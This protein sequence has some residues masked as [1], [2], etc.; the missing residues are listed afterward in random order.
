MNKMR[1][2]WSKNVVFPERKNNF[3]PISLNYTMHAHTG[4]TLCV[5]GSPRGWYMA[6]ANTV[7]LDLIGLFHITL[8]LTGHLYGD[9]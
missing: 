4:Q 6:P 2:N 8:N 9:R 5:S 1:S 7:T 3:P